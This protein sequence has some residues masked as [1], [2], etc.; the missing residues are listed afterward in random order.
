MWTQKHKIHN[1]NVPIDFKKKDKLYTPQFDYL[2]FN[3]SGN[4]V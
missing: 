1:I 2:Y 3:I 4:P